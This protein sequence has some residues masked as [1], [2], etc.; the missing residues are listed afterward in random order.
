MKET[1]IYQRTIMIFP[2][3]NNHEIIDEIRE[4]YDPLYHPGEAA[5][6]TGI[7]VSE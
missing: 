1:N 4:K 6:Y 2:Q 5:H 3:F 7:S